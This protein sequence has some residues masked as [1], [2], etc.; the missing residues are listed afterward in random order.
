MTEPAN[1]GRVPLIAGNW[2]MNLDLDEGRALAAEIV[3]GLRA[4]PW[5]DESAF[6]IG[7]FPPALSIPEVSRVLREKDARVLLGAQNMHPAASGAFT[8]EISSG[9]I[10]AAGASAVLL[11]HSERRHVF[12]ETSEFV[13]EKV[14]A[15]VGAG[16]TPMLC[17]G[18]TLEERDGGRTMDVVKEQLEKGLAGLSDA[19]ALQRVVVAY[20]PVWA[21]G[22]GRVATPEQAEEVHAFTRE[23]LAAAFTERGAN[24]SDAQGTRIL[25]GG[26]V[27]PENARGLL[28]KPNIDGALVGGASLDAGSFLGICAGAVPE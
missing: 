25:Y 4:K 19:S 16:L 21:I 9:M 24:A 5:A 20:E 27:K 18:E 8:G 13:G 6:E 15:A 10:L 26:S 7:L 12:G 11:G 22:T 28:S 23:Q 14:A 17:V 2:K 1:S 3:D